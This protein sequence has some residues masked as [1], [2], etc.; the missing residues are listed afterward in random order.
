M[1][2]TGYQIHTILACY[3]TAISLYVQHVL[4]HAV[5]LYAVCRDS[6]VRGK[7]HFLVPVRRMGVQN[8]LKNVEE[9][10]IYGVKIC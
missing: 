2:R 9:T 5:D 8:M 3:C 1:E 10:D 4:L 6:Y 7:H